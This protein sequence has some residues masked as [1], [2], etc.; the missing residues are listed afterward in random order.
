M[1]LRIL[2][3]F[4]FQVVL[5]FLLPS[6]RALLPHVPKIRERQEAEAA[7]PHLCRRLSLADKSHCLLPLVIA[8][9]AE[10]PQSQ[11]EAQSLFC[12]NSM[13]QTTARSLP[14][15]E[16]NL[17]RETFFLAA[18][19]LEIGGREG[20]TTTHCS[21]TWPQPAHCNSSGEKGHSSCD[22]TV[23]GLTLNLQLKPLSATHSSAGST[24][25]FLSP[26]QN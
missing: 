16:H 11:P 9:A 13:A 23:I 14:V 24:A 20:A 22:C 7:C 1:I 5:S 4:I 26:V 12:T 8:P 10:A 6:K 25:K 15:D 2:K 19:T 3:Y 21:V 17:K 18:A